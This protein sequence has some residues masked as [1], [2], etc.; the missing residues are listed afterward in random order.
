M[1]KAPQ[2]EGRLA[3]GGKENNSVLDRVSHCHPGWSAVVQPH[4]PGSSNSHASASQVAGITE[5]P[6]RRLVHWV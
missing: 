6:S 1:V 5:I 3:R 4:L 2:S